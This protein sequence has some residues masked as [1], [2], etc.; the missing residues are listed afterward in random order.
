MSLFRRKKS[1]TRGM[2][3]QEGHI[4]GVEAMVI[5]ETFFLTQK[6]KETFCELL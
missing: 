6:M 1:S 5:K 2:K 3:S 4:V